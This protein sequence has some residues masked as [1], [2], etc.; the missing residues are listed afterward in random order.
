M[1]FPKL[2]M[3]TLS[4]AGHRR[5]L[6]YRAGTS[7]ERVIDQ[8]FCN[9][10]Y[11]LRRLRRFPEI[12]DFLTLAKGHGK[13]PLIVDA[14]ANIGAST[15]YFAANIPDGLIVAIEPEVHNYCLLVENTRMLRVEPFQAA[16]SA[17]TTKLRVVDPGEGYWGY[18]TEPL[19]GDESDE[20]D[21][22]TSIVMSDIFA[23][24]GR[25]CFPFIVKIDIE[26]AEADLFSDNIE[27]VARTP[28]IIVELHDWLLP[29]KG[30]GHTFLRAIAFLDRD[31]IHI[32]ENIFSIENNLQGL[33]PVS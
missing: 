33:L 14:G 3:M 1:S 20:S 28:I 15:I 4:I 13:R 6:Y 18:R 23:R 25:T 2:D 16:V 21:D 27:W 29:K 26:G 9:Q 22:V 12:I 11:D 32:G 5:K 8:I 30:I 31:F 10:D 17:N 7:D 19:K 24:H